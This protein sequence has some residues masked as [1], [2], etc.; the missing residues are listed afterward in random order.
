MKVYERKPLYRNIRRFFAFL[1][2]ILCTVLQNSTEHSRYFSSDELGVP[3]ILIKHRTNLSEIRNPMLC[4]IGQ[5]NEKPPLPALAKWREYVT[6]ASCCSCNEK[7]VT[8]DEKIRFF[9]FFEK[10]VDI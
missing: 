2:Y 5:S 1:K 7:T 8:S 9:D 6:D 10:V 3:I 4:P